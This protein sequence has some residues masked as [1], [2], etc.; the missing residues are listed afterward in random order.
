MHAGNHAVLKITELTICRNEHLCGLG[1]LI[2]HMNQMSQ[3]KMPSNIAP[4]S[5]G[6]QK[7]KE[8]TFLCR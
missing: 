8:L 2:L 4:V 7:K 1:G 6:C 5:R 3:S